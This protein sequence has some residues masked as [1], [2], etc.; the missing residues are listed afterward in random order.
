M[1]GFSCRVALP[2]AAFQHAQSHP[3]ERPQDGRQARR[4]TG[5]SPTSESGSRVP[6]YRLHRALG[7]A[8]VSLTGTE[9]YLSRYGSA[10]SR[11]EYERRMAEWLAGGR[12]PLGGPGARISPA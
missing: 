8:V 3:P 11:G 4:R 9:Y 2:R 7:Q 12:D 6:A 5:P 1:N 10:G